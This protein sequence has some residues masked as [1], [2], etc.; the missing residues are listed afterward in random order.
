MRLALAVVALV[1]PTPGSPV[2]HEPFT[3]LDCPAHPSTTLA[4]E[5][6]AE[7]ALL[8]SD[9]AIDARAAKV[10]RLLATPQARTA[11]VAGER[12]WLAYRRSSCAAAASRYAGGTIQPVAFAQCEQAR[13]VT[14]LRDLAVLLREVAG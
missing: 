5:G 14:H 7:R 2:I 8:A 3:P 13:N 6:C 11:F 9:R 4:L 12:S 1:A 10:Y